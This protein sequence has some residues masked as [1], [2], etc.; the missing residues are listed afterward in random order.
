MLDRGLFL[1]QLAVRRQLAAMPHDLFLIRLIHDA[2][3]K[4]FPGERLWTSAQLT[5][6]STLRFLRARNREGCHV[7]FQPWA[8]Q[9]NAGYILVDLDGADE[10]VVH[11]M[12]ADGYQPCIV[13]QTSPGCLQAWV[14]ISRAPLPPALATAVSRQLADTYGADRASA[15]W[16]HVGRLAGFTNQKPQ[17]RTAAGYAPWV[18]IVYAHPGLASGADGLLQQAIRTR[19]PAPEDA[20]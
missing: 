19:A 4:P 11:T 6:V 20:L 8:G 18:R 5:S 10:S 2:T 12:R 9:Q 3:R 1:T 14:H 15:D 13:L 16:R 7:Y 17:R